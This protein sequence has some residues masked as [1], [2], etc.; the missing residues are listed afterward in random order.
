MN[1]GRIT[2]CDTPERLKE[3]FEERHAVEVSLSPASDLEAK[4]GGLAGVTGVTRIGDKYRLYV[5][6]VSDGVIS[7]VSFAGENGLR[8]IS[9]DTLRP[10][11]EDAFVR[12][13]GLSPEVLAAEKEARKKGGDA[14]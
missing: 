12:L 7:I 5:E 4:L 2:T 11:L 14:G 13:T 9:L 8:I 6:D 3:G 1:R 10:S